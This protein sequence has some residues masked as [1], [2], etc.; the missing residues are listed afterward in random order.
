VCGYLEARLAEVRSFAAKIDKVTTSSSLTLFDR[1]VDILTSALSCGV[2]MIDSQSLVS[3]RSCI[4][5]ALGWQYRARLV[6]AGLI[7]SPSGG[8]KHRAVTVYDDDT[9]VPVKSAGKLSSVKDAKVKDELG[10]DDEDDDEDEGIGEVSPTLP[11]IT[12]QLESLKGLHIAMPEASVQPCSVRCNRFYHVIC[13]V[14]RLL[15]YKSCTRKRRSG[16]TQSPALALKRQAAIPC[17]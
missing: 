14:S 5:D 11:M 10:S 3:L 8:Y 6:L 1:V 9:G 7:P 12:Q 13:V 16:S 2:S 17:E 15:S 4:V